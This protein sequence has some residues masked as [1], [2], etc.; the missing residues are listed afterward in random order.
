MAAPV[1]DAKPKKRKKTGGRKKGTPNKVGLTVK[2]G[3]IEAATRI[4]LDGKGFGGMVGFMIRAGLL[5]PASLMTQ[6]GRLVPTEVSV[7]VMHT[8]DLDKLT[9]DEIDVL[10]KLA[11]KAQ[12]PMIEDKRVDPHTIELSSEDYE[13]KVDEILKSVEPETEPANGG[14]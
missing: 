1:P 6:L 10:L 11:N 3:F 12:K 2:E 7:G 9:P 14:E 8:W 13:V 4:G 5:K